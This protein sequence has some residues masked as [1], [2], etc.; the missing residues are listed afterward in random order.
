MSQTQ[1]PESLN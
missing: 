1:V